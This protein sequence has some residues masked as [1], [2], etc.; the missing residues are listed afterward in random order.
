M[1]VLDF[2]I[3]ME[4]DGFEYY[5]DLAVS[6]TL[7]GLKTIFTS[8]AEDELKHAEFFKALN[9]GGPVGKMP[10]SG[11]LDTAQSLFK[12][13]PAGSEALK[14]I[15]DS[16]KAYQ[17]AMKLEANS[18]RFYEELAGKE[19]NIEVRDLLLQIAEE[20]HKHFNILENV[21][22]FV[23]APNQSLEWGEFSNLGEFRQFGR[24]TDG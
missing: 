12:Q 7:P 13:L 9:A 17:H 14:N 1:N 10:A 21:Y 18:F 4:N 8:L 20:E 23:N 19:T 22:N 24:E 2:A 15:A 3:E 6:S 16:L 5:R 11:A